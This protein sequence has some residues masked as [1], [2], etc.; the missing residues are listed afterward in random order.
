ME[1]YIS[2]LITRLNRQLKEADKEKYTLEVLKQNLSYVQEVVKELKLYSHK[3]SFANVSEEIRFYKEFQPSI[4]QF[5]FYYSQLYKIELK[6]ITTSKNE[7]R[8]LYEQELLRINKFFSKIKLFYRYYRG[9]DTSLDK[10]FFTHE[11]LYDDF[12]AAFDE[13]FCTKYSYRASQ[14]IAFEN[15][16]HY[17]EAELRRLDHPETFGKIMPELKAEWKG[18][19]SDAAEL[20]IGV[21]LAEAIYIDDRPATISQITLSFEQLFMIDLKDF[22]N[23]D[24]AN[25]SRKKDLTPF[26]NCLIKKF[27]ERTT[28]LNK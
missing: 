18:S 28:R 25:R 4:Y 19:K 22:K 17:L 8:G 15:L 26:L 2:N 14:I 3:I 5:L 27:N 24:Y 7:I 12:S 13:S 20:I 9:N 21:Q 16:H 1:S 23:L 10:A 6:K 11:A